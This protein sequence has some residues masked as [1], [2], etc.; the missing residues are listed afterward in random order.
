MKKQNYFGLKI[1]SESYIL[2]DNVGQKFAVYLYEHTKT[3]ERVRIY[4]IILKKEF[5]LF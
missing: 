3:V 5:Y 4:G 2:L 1:H